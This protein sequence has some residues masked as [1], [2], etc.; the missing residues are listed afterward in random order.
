[1]GG[2]QSLSGQARP[3]HAMPFVALN[4]DRLETIAAFLHG[5]FPMVRSQ[6]LRQ[7]SAACEMSFLNPDSKIQD[8]NEPYEQQF[9]VGR[10][11]SNL[12]GDM[13]RSIPSSTIGTHSP[14]RCRVE[15]FWT[16]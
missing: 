1:M 14:W 6:L 8:A 5:A 2:A 15:L 3:C 7:L 12:A 10:A 11:V 4:L 16:S 13:A 9:A